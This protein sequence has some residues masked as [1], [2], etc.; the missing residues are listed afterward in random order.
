[1]DAPWKEIAM[2]MLSLLIWKACLYYSMRNLHSM[3]WL[4]GHG[5]ELHCHGDDGITIEGVLHLGF[6]P[7]ILRKMILIGCADQC[8]NYVILAMKSQFQSLD[9]IVRRVVLD[10]IPHGFSPINGS[11]STL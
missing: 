10:R 1:M 11:A 5:K 2:D 8:E 9:V 4:Q 7:N 3:S 6:P